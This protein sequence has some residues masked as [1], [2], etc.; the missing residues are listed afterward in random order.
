MKTLCKIVVLAFLLNGCARKDPVENIIDYHQQHISDVLNFSHNT[1][2]QTAEI[3]FLESELDSCRV[4]L[5][6]VKQAHDLSIQSE[7][8]KTS[9]WRLATMGLFMALVGI[10]LYALKRFIKLV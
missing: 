5:A 1:F 2:E 3:K 7:K 9:Y 6:D 4:A 8:A 10:V